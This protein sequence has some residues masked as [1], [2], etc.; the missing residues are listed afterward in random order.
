MPELSR[1]LDSSSAVPAEAAWKT[2]LLDAASG[3]PV[4]PNG[5]IGFRYADSGEGKW[6]LDLEGVV[7]GALA[8]RCEVDAESAEV[9]LPSSRHPT[10]RATCCAAACRSRGIGDALVTTVFDLML[11]QYGVARPGLPGDWPTGYDDATAPYTPAWQATITSVPAEACIR[12]AREFATNAEESD[13]RSMIIMGA[14]ICQWFHADATYRSILSLLILT[15]CDGPQRRRLGALRRPGEVPADHRLA[16]AGQ[17]VG[18]VPA[19]ADHDRHRV[20]VH[21]HRPVALRRLRG[22][23]ARLT[24]GRG[25]PRRHAHR[26]HHRPVGA[27]GLDAVLS[28]VRREPAGSGRPGRPPRSRPARRQM[29]RV[30]RLRADRRQL[31]FSI[32]DVDAPQNWPRVLTLWRSNLLGSSAKGNEYFLK[33]LL[34]THSN[35][36]ADEGATSARAM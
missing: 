8:A 15:G 27:D 25:P 10:A 20:L 12:I 22:R 23:R 16:L 33:Y 31:Q 18:L 26:R 28:A 4:V 14:G 30:R 13:G 3:Q 19:A 34:G 21:A 36:M 7:A 17:R 1:H 11:A 6:N 9:L 24:A 5:S 35:V 29:P 32:E 2:V